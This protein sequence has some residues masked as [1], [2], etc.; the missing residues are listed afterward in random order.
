MIADRE[1]ARRNY[2]D[3]LSLEAVRSILHISKRKAAWMLQNGIIECEISQKK[4]KQYNVRLEDLFA[5][6]DKVEHGDSS[7]QIPIGIFNA[8]KSSGKEKKERL[9]TNPTR[10]KKPTEAFRAWLMDKWSNESEMLCTGE[11]SSLTGYTQ[12]TV[13]RW[14]KQGTLQSVK[15]KNKLVVAKEWLLDFYCEEA[16]KIVQKCEKH[17]ELMQNFYTR[18][19][20]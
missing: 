18:N 8:K 15:T 12:Q 5:Y 13:Q 1:E 6:L 10:P 20:K 9:R 4:T 3:T 11:I 14:T 19:E 16:Y 2:P 7:I 17:R